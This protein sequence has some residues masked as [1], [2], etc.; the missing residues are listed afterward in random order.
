MILAHAISW[1]AGQCPR[2][3]SL[4]AVDKSARAKAPLLFR[5]HDRDSVLPDGMLAP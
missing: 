1:G 3:I 2:D 5:Y 4:I